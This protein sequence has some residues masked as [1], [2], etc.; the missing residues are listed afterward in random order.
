[1]CSVLGGHNKNEI[2]SAVIT[3]QQSV[4]KWYEVHGLCVI[5][6]RLNT[7]HA[8]C[9]SVALSYYHQGSFLVP[10]AGL[11]TIHWRQC[12]QSNSL[13]VLRHRVDMMHTALAGCLVLAAWLLGCL[14][15]P[16]RGTTSHCPGFCT[17][18]SAGYCSH[19][20]IWI[21]I[22]KYLI[23]HFSVKYE[24]LWDFCRCVNDD[25]TVIFDS[26]WRQT[27]LTANWRDHCQW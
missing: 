15:A 10:P 23:L 2:P 18:H 8:V 9:T 11:I 20:T 6:C 27:L 3:L 25:L 21:N 16:G 24:L 4:C 14:A 22:Y 13:L 17:A 12:C 7:F 5:V 1:M 26:G 19:T